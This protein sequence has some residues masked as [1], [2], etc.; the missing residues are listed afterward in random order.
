M[1]PIEL[2]Q[3]NFYKISLYN[4]YEFVALYHCRYYKYVLVDP[5]L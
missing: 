2:C 3:I 5:N 1:Q 4:D